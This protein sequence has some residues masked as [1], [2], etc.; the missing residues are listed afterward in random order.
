M[1]LQG[2]SAFAPGAVTVE[3][4]YLT[5]AFSKEVSYLL[6]LDTGRMLAGFYETAGIPNGQRRYS[7]W[8]NSL[9]GG[10]TMG[11]Y[12]TALVQAY[13]SG[14][15]TAEQKS[16][17]LQ[18]I[19][20]LVE[21]LN[22]CQEALGTGFVF[23]ATV[24]DKGNVEVQFDNVEVNRTNIF[25]QAW[26]PW[27]T[28]HKILAGLNAAAAM[29]EAEAEPVAALALAVADRLGDWVYHRVSTWSEKTQRTVLAIEYGGMNDALYDLYLL[30]GK[31][32]YK[33]AAHMF[34]QVSLF[35]RVKNA[36]PGDDVLNDL[37]ANTTIPKFLGAL[38]AYLVDPEENGEY[39]SYVTAFYDLVTEHHT[40]ITGGNSEWEHFGRD[41]VLDGERTYA[42]CETCNA[43]NMLKMT[44]A[45]FLLTGD[46][47]YLD[48]YE[49]TFTNSILSSQ[50]PDTGMTTYWQPMASGYFKVYGSPENSFWCC[51]GTGMENFTK[52]GESFYYRKGNDL[53]VA[54]YYS[55][56]LTWEGMTLSQQST[57]PV[58]DTVTFTLTGD[59]PGG[60]LLRLP[61]WLMAPASI[62]VNGAPYA[63]DTVNGSF[64]LI[65]GLRDK[66]IVTLTLP[67]GVRALNLPDGENTF[68]FAY[69]P[70][71]LS[72]PLGSSSMTTSVDGVDVYIPKTKILDKAYLPSGSEQVT[73]L[74]GTVADFMENL[75][76]HL[77]RNEGPELSFTLTGTDAQLTYT[78]H[79]RQYQQRYA[80]YLRFSDD[81]SALSDAQVLR[82]KA[83]AR[84]EKMRLDVIQPGYGQ[85]E[86]DAL[87]NMQETGTGS[88]G[89]TDQGTRRYALA[90]GSFAYSMAVDE[91]G[92]DLLITLSPE[93]NGKALVVTAGEMVVY[94][95]VLSLSGTQEQDVV[96]PLPQEAVQQA[97]DGRLWIAFAGKEGDSAAVRGFVYTMKHLSRDT[98]VSAA[99]EEAKITYTDAPARFEV[100]VPEGAKELSLT[101]TLPGAYAYLTVNGAIK[102]ADGPLAF[103]IHEERHTGYA[104]RVYADDQLTYRDYALD[105]VRPEVEEELDEDL[106]YFV[107]CGSH[108]PTELPKGEVRGQY[109][110]ITE[111]LYGIDP[112]TG[113]A[114]G[115]VDDGFDQYGG[116]TISAG[117]YTAN[118][119]CYEANA[120]RTN[121][122]KEDTNRYTKNQF[123]SGIPRHLRYDFELPDGTYEVEI[124]FADPWGCSRNPNVYAY[125]G[126]ENEQELLHHFDVADDYGTA[127]VTVFGGRLTLD[128]TTADKAINVTYIMIRK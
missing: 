121:A 89:I 18:Q 42:N 102:N 5:N 40:Y 71:V 33:T 2:L 125:Q 60:L 28:M 23:G 115:L 11:H 119:W 116:S 66:D 113:Y 30:T 32:E 69:G 98:A 128:I 111:Q 118:T 93:D 51:T 41:D 87:H 31:P 20:E 80:L 76:Q 9:I 106:L 49:N 110:S 21:G 120:N 52:L 124:G 24:A 46:N 62:T 27:Y 108:T 34:D 17:L 48:W 96:I 91:E 61:G 99:C 81:T 105:F 65:Q 100:T 8:E 112:V 95:T 47:R 55:S 45:L 10:H 117:L 35:E 26:V 63:Y 75:S 82:D 56:T 74:E 16:A 86:S 37:H 64:A 3:D 57:I 126:L 6:S 39:L 84:M 90:G 78:P 36:Q 73:V 127:A 1:D 104:L 19:S 4:G 88:V 25:T 72:A 83:A 70:V 7:G 50:N 68:A 12:M 101:F 13:E 107:N 58:G 59:L 44:K 109:N 38:K 103:P 43:Y 85:Y 94:D 14:D 92:T 29:T 22:E 54:Q 122:Y 114:W 123:E 77:I 53:V 97:R 67:M 79:Y 15:A